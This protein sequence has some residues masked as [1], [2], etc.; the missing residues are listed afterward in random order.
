MSTPQTT[1][2]DSIGALLSPRSIAVIGA[3][4][5]GARIGGRP[6][7][8][9]IDAGY[10]GAIYPVNPSHP[11]VQG[12][13]CYPD[14]ASIAAPVDVAVIALPSEH[15]VEAVQACADQ[16]VKGVI[17]FSAGFAEVDAAGAALQ[18]EVCRIARSVGMRLL[19]P[20]CLGAFDSAAGFFATFAQVFDGGVVRPGPIAIASQSGACG[21]YLVH[22]CMQRDIGVRYWITT[23]NEADVDLSECMLWLARAPEVKVI[24]AYAESVRNGATFIEALET[25]RRNRKPVVMLKVG[26]SSSGARAAASHTGALAGEDAVYDAVLRQYGV[27]RA[28]SIEQLLDI[29]NACADGIFPDSRSIGLVT[30]SGGLGAQMADVADARG[31]DVA[32]LPQA[33]QDRIK[34]ILPFAAAGNPIDITA[35]AVNDISLISRAMEIVL[36]EGDYGAVVCFLVS[37]PAS[38]AQTEPLLRAFTALRQRFPERLIVLSFAAPPAI[39]RSFEAAG[40]PVF[41]DVNRAVITIAALASFGES[42]R[43]VR[44]DECTPAAAV[45]AAPTPWAEALDEHSAKQL[46]AQNGIPSWP[47]HVA[48]D[49]AGVGRV[50]VDLGCPVALKILSPDIPHKSE[51]GGVLLNVASPDAATEAA[52]ALLE[53]VALLRPDA[54]LTGVLVSPMCRG[55]VETICGVFRDPV[56]GPV[57]MFGLGGIH[58]EVLRDVAFRLAPI[59]EREALSMVR[60]IRGHAL[61]EGVRGAPPSDVDALAKALSRLSW[62]AVTHRD[63]VEEIDLNPFVVMPRGEGAFALDA[64]IIEKESNSLTG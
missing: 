26:R 10:T 20:N 21:A 46:L 18:Q 44:S 28:D 42:F 52:Q 2:V 38:A 51:V 50:A 13:K 45:D 58:V 54:R 17:L 14:L 47:E 43:V 1:N 35:Q 48:T 23:G 34:A 3:S 62:F 55:G 33:A 36:T 15:V 64:L 57:V 63:R 12:L 29:A 9:L 11:S 31:L 53:R 27:F 19:G 37:A 4:S 25:A 56:F 61:L 32:P 40:F 6:L 59:N 24:V 7:R 30:G 16:G 60:E 5:N 22:L 49:A 41:E 39:V 8:Y